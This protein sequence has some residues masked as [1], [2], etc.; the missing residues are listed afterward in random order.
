[1]KLHTHH[2]T[3]RLRRSDFLTYYPTRPTHI[4]QY[5]YSQKPVRE[6][7]LWRPLS[8]PQSGF[9]FFLYTVNSYSF[10]DTKHNTMSGFMERKKNA[11]KQISC[12]FFSTYNCCTLFTR[13]QGVKVQFC[14]QFFHF[15]SPGSLLKYRSNIIQVRFAYSFRLNDF[16]SHAFGTIP[17]DFQ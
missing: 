13:V 8:S 6:Q 4:S 17:D 2:C 15:C 16:L 12:V 14:M 3:R 1:M 10:R 7:I 9:F 11:V 5:L